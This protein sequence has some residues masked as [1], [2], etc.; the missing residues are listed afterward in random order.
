ML[1]PRPPALLVLAA[2][3]VAITAALLGALACSTG[4]PTDPA[5]V[6]T[7]GNAAAKNEYHRLEQQALTEIRAWGASSDKL[8]DPRP[9][10]AEKLEAFAREYPK[11]PEAS[12]ALLGV[13]Q[14]REA[15]LDIDGFFKAYDLLLATSPDAS[16][17]S[18]VFDQITTLRVIEAGGPGIFATGGEMERRE[19]YKA[20]APRIAADIEKTIAVAT[21][22]AVLANAHFAVAETWY[23]LDVDLDRALEHYK[24]VATQFGDSPWAEQAARRGAEIER[25]GIG[26]AAPDFSGVAIDGKKIRLSSLKGKLVLIDFWATWCG[27]CVKELPSLKRVYQRFKDQGFTIIGVSL[28]SDPELVARFAER[29]G[30]TWPII[31]DGADGGMATGP[32]ATSYDVEAIPMSYLVDRSGTIRARRLLGDDVERAVEKLMGS[33]VAAVKSL[34]E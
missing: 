27:P 26:R 25:L 3:V 19:A 2:T 32:L 11:A 12:A 13:L 4:A 21:S 30:M 18:A 29:N 5:G 14:L 20:A 8:P 7:A 17:V 33:R 16:G 10:W 15:A 31:V 9:G 23:L 6:A 1:H 24:T 22:P 28:E 34:P